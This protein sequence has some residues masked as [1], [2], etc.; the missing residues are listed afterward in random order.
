MLPQ[1][2]HIHTVFSSGDSAV[3]PQQTIELIAAVHHARTVGISDH[4]EYLRNNRFDEYAA[5]VQKYGFHLGAEIVNN[6]D[7]DFALS[8]PLEY[9]VFHCYNDE[10]SYRNAQRLADCGSPLIIAHPMALNTDLSRVPANAIVEINNR[11][12][13]RDDWKAYYTPWVGKFRFIFSSD[14]HQPNWLNQTVARYVGGVLGIEETLLFGD[15]R[16]KSVA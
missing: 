3:V 11:Y 10:I 7:V 4:V 6:D 9:R 1:D 15:K 14:A 13:W 5:K 2:L 8:L 12:I 16:D